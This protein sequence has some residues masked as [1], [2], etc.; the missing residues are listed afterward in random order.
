MSKM[1]W[2]TAAGGR[3]SGHWAVPQLTRRMGVVRAAVDW[4]Q[5]PTEDE[6]GV[7]WLSE[8]GQWWWRRVDPGAR[9]AGKRTRWYLWKG[10]QQSYQANQNVEE[11]P[12][13]EYWEGTEENW[14]ETE[15]QDWVG[16]WKGR[17]FGKGMC[18]RGSSGPS[19]RH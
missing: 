1:V 9:G 16:E 11:Y 18:G 2:N 7:E 15:E 4:A 13:E 3:S 8:R 19:I 5:E 17:N 14:E 10:K 6:E 12:E